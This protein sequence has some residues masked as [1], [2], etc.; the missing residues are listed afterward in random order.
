MA[1]T[2]GA[3]VTA[4]TEAQA[5]AENTAAEPQAAQAAQPAQA[6]QADTEAIDKTL[7]EAEPKAEEAAPEM[8]DKY[9]FHLPEGL[10]LTEDIEKRFTELAHGMKL[11]QEQAD[12]LVKLHSDIVMDMMK[13]AEAQ[14]NVW[15]DELQKAGLADAEKLRAAKMAVDTFDPSG[16]V[17][18]ELLESGLAYSPNVQR[19]L[20]AMGS[21]LMEDT[22][23]DNKPAAQAKSA[24]ELLFQNSKY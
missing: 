23:P 21:V 22:A 12:G 1:E 4:T 16:K 2:E 8:P 9:E 6:A 7:T 15:A 24:A 20:Q 19:M 14:K 18:Q 11:T 10:K 5:P 17:M 3:N 13:Q